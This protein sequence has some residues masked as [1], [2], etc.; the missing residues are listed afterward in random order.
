MKKEIIKVK[1]LVLGAGLGFYC[2]LIN[3]GLIL[4]TAPPPQRG[5]FFPR[6]VRKKAA[7]KN[8]YLASFSQS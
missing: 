7:L 3:R 6:L 8:P 1:Y 5:E 4:L 2:R